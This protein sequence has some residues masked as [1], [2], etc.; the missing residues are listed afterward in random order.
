MAKVLYFK[1]VHTGSRYRVLRKFKDGEGNEKVELQG[2]TAAFVEPFDKERF[3]RMGYTLEV[4]DTSEDA[5][6]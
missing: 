4:E 2:N 6:E 1:N 5:D 3:K